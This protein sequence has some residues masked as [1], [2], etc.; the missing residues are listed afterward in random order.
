MVGRQPPRW[1]CNSTALQVHDE[2]L[3]ERA[4]PRQLP[5]SHAAFAGLHAH[6]HPPHL[7]EGRWPKADTDQQCC[8]AS[9]VPLCMVA[10]TIMPITKRTDR[11]RRW[12]GRAEAIVTAFPESG[13]NGAIS[14]IVDSAGAE[15]YTRGDM[16]LGQTGFMKMP[17]LWRNAQT[18]C[19]TRKRTKRCPVTVMT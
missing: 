14:S 11:R 8:Q 16:S 5:T 13:S 7:S 18:V 9:I 10:V 4:R 17:K 12:P 15:G 6:Y 1:L 2:E 19:E 3:A